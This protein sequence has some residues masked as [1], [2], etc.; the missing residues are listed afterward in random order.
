MGKGGARGGERGLGG[1]TG[2]Q[3]G[4][5]CG[6][7]VQKPVWGVKMVQGGEAAGGACKGR[8]SERARGRGSENGVLGDGRVW[9]WVC[10]ACKAVQGGGSLQD[11]CARGRRV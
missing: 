9:R 2:V 11:G 3:M 1:E 7:G 10:K 5:G 6:M 4:A 8:E